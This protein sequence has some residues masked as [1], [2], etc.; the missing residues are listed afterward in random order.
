MPP[1]VENIRMDHR[2]K[3]LLRDADDDELID[4]VLVDDDHA[5]EVLVR[6]HAGWMLVL[7]ERYTNDRALAEDCVQEA[8]SNAFNRL[9]SFERKSSLKTWLHRIV[10]NQALMK[11]RG[12]RAKNEIALNSL[13]P[14]FDLNECRIEGPPAHILT[15]EQILADDRLRSLVRK[16]IDKLPDSYRNVLYL[17]DIEEMTT[18]EVAEALDLSEANVK[19]RLH[20]ARAALKRLLEPLLRGELG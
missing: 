11:L 14:E 4:R 10:V 7:A 9:G 3:P 16:N 20:R 6:R 2:S 5:A 15:P 18:S 8:F 12:R 19:V 13:Q 1:I 17:R